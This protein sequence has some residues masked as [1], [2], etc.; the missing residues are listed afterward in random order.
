MVPH[1]SRE[2]IAERSHGDDPVGRPRVRGLDSLSVEDGSEDSHAKKRL[3]DLGTKRLGG[4]RTVR[5]SAR[6]DNR[7]QRDERALVS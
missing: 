3:E 7:H 4:L 2:P 1:T 5:R 6:G